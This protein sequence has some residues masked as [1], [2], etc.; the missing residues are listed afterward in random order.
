LPGEEGWWK[1]RKRGKEEEERREGRRRRRRRRRGREDGLA[2]K[3]GKNIQERKKKRSAA[4]NQLA[5]RLKKGNRA[6]GVYSRFRKGFKT[7]SD[8]F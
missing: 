5:K 3:A 4:S 2:W 6:A 8:A 1:E 7:E